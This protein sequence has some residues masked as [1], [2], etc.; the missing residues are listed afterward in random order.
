MSKRKRLHFFL[1]ISLVEVELGRYNEICNVIFSIILFRKKNLQLP[2]C[3]RKKL[4]KICSILKMKNWFLAPEILFFCTFCLQIFFFFLAV[5]KKFKQTLQFLLQT[6]GISNLFLHSLQIL[7]KYWRTVYTDY[8]DVT[9][10]IAKSCK[11]RPI[12]AS[13][14][15]SSMTHFQLIPINF[16]FSY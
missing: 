13:I 14:Y 3:C 4:R 8:H 12:R 1:R 10:D 11:T 6:I 2:F 16:H 7:G 15:T 9:I 5:R